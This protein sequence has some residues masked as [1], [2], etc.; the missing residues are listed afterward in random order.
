MRDQ[1]IPLFIKA[2]TIN[3]PLQPSLPLIIDDHILLDMLQIIKNLEHAIIYQ[4]LYLLCFFFYVYPIYC[5][6]L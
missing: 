5:L 4:A 6:I 2:I 3:R 1:R